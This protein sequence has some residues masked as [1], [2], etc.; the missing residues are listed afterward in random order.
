MAYNSSLSFDTVL[1]IESLRPG[2]LRT[3]MDL[4]DTTIA[5]AALSEGI[6]GELFQVETR[7]K[8]FGALRRALD[9]AE[10][11]R[12]PIIHFETHGDTLGIQLGSNETVLWTALAPALAKINTAC[13]MNL[14]VV[15][16]A[17]HGWHLTST[18][19]PVDRSPAWAVL[20]P[21]EAIA[22]SRIYEA[23][24]TFYSELFTRLDLG[25]AIRAMNGDRDVEDWDYRII[26]AD[27][28]LCQ[29]FKQYIRDLETEGSQSERVNRMVAEIAR[30]QNLDVT[31]T[32]AR[33]VEITAAIGDHKRWFNH[34]R[35]HFLMLDLFPQNEGRFP[36]SYEDCA[37]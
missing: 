4:F 20:G 8:F 18:L 19:R 9:L 1:I 37:G 12:A 29:V 11:G 13:Q 5:P 26:T 23:T 22:A 7:T 3:G 34:Y 2:D 28:I 35:S 36:R 14:L 15:A 17:C 32:M 30:S 6:V 16:A 21:P 31:Q 10:S 27:L 24:R 25:A 33:R